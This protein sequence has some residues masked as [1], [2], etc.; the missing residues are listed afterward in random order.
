M[1][2]A[3]IACFAHSSIDGVGVLDPHRVGELT[4]RQRD[5]HRHRIGRDR[6]AAAM[7]N[8]WNTC[9]SPP[10]TFRPEAGYAQDLVIEL[11]GF[12]ALVQRVYG[13]DEA[14]FLPGRP[15]LHEP[16][17]ALAVADQAPVGVRE[18]RALQHRVEVRVLDHDVGAEVER[19]AHDAVVQ[20]VV[21]TAVDVD[22]QSFGYERARELLEARLVPRE[23]R[24]ARV[25]ESRRA[26][27]ARVRDLRGIVADEELENGRHGAREPSRS[28]ER[29]VG[30][31]RRID[32]DEDTLLLSHGYSHPFR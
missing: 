14:R 1:W 18:D 25:G 8:A 20:R 22:V 27:A 16:Q 6:Q 17:R 24:G 5:R 7:S 2:S 9:S 32:D 21:P 29:R 23:D 31:R 11:S 15:R 12:V 28:L 4:H 10:S 26:A 30:R 19:F 13:S 3:G